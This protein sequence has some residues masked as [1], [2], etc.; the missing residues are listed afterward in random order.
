MDKKTAQGI[1]ETRE[2]L[3]EHFP[4]SSAYYMFA[5]SL[6][7]SRI[8]FAGKARKNDL[9][10]E[11]SYEGVTPEDSR[12]RVRHYLH[13][14]FSLNREHLTS[15]RASTVG[16]EGVAI[17]TEHV[18]FYYPD[19]YYARVN[20]PRPAGK[21]RQDHAFV[22]VPTK[23]PFIAVFTNATLVV[24]FEYG[25]DGIF[26]STATLRQSNVGEHMR[27]FRRRYKKQ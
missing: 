10:V 3:E 13:E 24:V 8:E 4:T 11:V 23:R 22:M 25:D 6:N 7:L 17:T 14:A 9:D 1:L 15:L 16:M 18:V 26:V 19:R 21:L 2:V 20:L 5:D 12:T 27:Q